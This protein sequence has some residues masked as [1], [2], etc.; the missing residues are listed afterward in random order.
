MDTKENSSTMWT[1]NILKDWANYI[2]IIIRR[3]WMTDE[4]P[5]IYT[6]CRTWPR[7]SFV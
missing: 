4:Y 2:A 3:T 1:F 6:S 7:N 5:Y